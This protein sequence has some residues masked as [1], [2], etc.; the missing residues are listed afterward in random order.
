MRRDSNST[1]DSTRFSVRMTSGR[2]SIRRSSLMSRMSGGTDT[3][4]PPGEDTSIPFQWLIG[5]DACKRDYFMMCI[6]D[7]IYIYFNFL[8]F[9][10]YFF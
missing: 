10:F 2:K 8:F 9:I 4:Q 3:K 5:T 7:F 1:R 6:F